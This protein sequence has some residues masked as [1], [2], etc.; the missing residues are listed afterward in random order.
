MKARL[1]KDRPSGYPSPLR[2]GAVINVI[3][4]EGGTTVYWAEPRDPKVQN[5]TA[6]EPTKLKIGTD[7]VILD[8]NDTSAIS[9]TSETKT[10]ESK[11]EDAGKI[12]ITIMALALLGYMAY[13]YTPFF[14]N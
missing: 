9:G 6:P 13:K 7:V 14:K 1:L 10:E 11:K 3:V 8:S 12:I 2:A 5:I 4:P